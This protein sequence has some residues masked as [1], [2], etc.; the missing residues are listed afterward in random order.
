MVSVCT[1]APHPGRWTV[2]FLWWFTHALVGGSAR[3]IFEAHLPDILAH[4]H[5]YAFNKEDLPWLLQAG[6]ITTVVAKLLSGPVSSYLGV[7]HIGWGSL[8]TCGAC[9][10]GDPPSPSPPLSL[11][12]PPFLYRSPP[13]P[14]LPPLPPH[15]LFHS[16]WCSWLISYSVS[17][18]YQ[19]LQ[20]QLCRSGW[21]CSIVWD[22]HFS[23]CLPHG[24]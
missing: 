9:L 1:T 21:E 15:M 23:R 19:T 11:S 18:L 8:V 3:V 2:L 6:T 16:P 14:S 13:P 20:L 17:P 4:S 5:T 22:I 12:L 10:V 7:Y 24:T